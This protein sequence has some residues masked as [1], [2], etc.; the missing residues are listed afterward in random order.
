MIDCHR[1]STIAVHHMY[2]SVCVNHFFWPTFIDLTCS[3]A[4]AEILISNGA[5]ICAPMNKRDQSL[6]CYIR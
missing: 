1:E 5:E 6:I 2:T 4:A 3:E